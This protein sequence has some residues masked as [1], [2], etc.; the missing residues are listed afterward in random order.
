M[1][2]SG[3]QN[4]GPH[5]SGYNPP[6]FPNRQAAFDSRHSNQQQYQPHAT[7]PIVMGP[8]IRM[9]FNGEQ[10]NRYEQGPVPQ[11][12]SFPHAEQKRMVSFPPPE[13][14][15]ISHHRHNSPGDIR[16]TR[17]YSPNPF[18]AHRGRSQKRMHSD[19]FGAPRGAVSRAPAPPAVPSFGNALPVK[20]PL[21]QESGKKPR[22]KKRKHNQLGLTPKVEEHESSEEEEDVDEESKLAAQAGIKEGPKEE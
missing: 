6:N 1:H 3:P 19:A 16:P 13:N 8:P 4:N 12:H 20:P 15:V 14:H 10:P 7:P 22:K 9:G 21:P 18:P 11:P 2:G 17:H 5:S